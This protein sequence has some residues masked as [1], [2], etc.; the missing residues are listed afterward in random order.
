[1]CVERVGEYKNMP[2]INENVCACLVDRGRGTDRSALAA[3]RT[4][5][6]VGTGWLFSS[7]F[8]DTQTAAGQS[9]A[10][11]IYI[12]SGVVVGRHLARGGGGG[13]GWGDH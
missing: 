5:G 10:M 4:D 9:A 11:L 1:M 12:C 8:P 13:G 3:G 6:R 2:K 7:F